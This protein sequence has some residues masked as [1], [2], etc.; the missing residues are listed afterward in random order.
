MGAKGWQGLGN[1]LGEEGWE[2]LLPTSHFSSSSWLSRPWQIPGGWSWWKEHQKT[3]LKFQLETTPP[4]ALMQPQKQPLV[5]AGLLQ[6]SWLLLLGKSMGQRDRSWYT[7]LQVSLA[8]AQ[9]SIAAQ[10]APLPAQAQ[11]TDCAS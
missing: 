8:G 3:T 6:C 2:S 1:T 4:L 11:S 9:P 7:C 5:P 10:H